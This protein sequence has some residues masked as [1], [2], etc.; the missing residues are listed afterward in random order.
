[1]VGVG[2]FY[3]NGSDDILFRNAS[4][5]DTWLE[6]MSDGNFVGWRQVGGSVTHYAVVGVGDFYGNGDD[7]ILFRNNSTGDTWLEV[8]SN[9][10]SAGWQQIG[11]SDTQFSV[12]GVGDFYG[13]GT[14]DI[15]FR[16]NTTGDLWVEAM[17]KAALPAGTRSAAPT[18]AMRS[19]AS[20]I[21]SATA[22]TTSC[23]A[24]T[25]PA[26]PGLPP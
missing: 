13:D 8:L 14:D 24:T 9:G 16:N 6:V 20:A 15:L 12:V 26:I 17:N 25:R 21:I 18:P 3:G 19:W 2:D 23:S 11:G 7:D 4:T 22:P 1:V 10:S 5:G